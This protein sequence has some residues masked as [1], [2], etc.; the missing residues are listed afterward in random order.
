MARFDAERQALAMMDHPNIARVLDAGATQTGRPYFVMEL[1]RGVR[2]TGFCDEN[3]FDTRQRLELFIQVCQAIQ[4]AHQKGIIH[5]DIKPSNVLVAMVD[6]KALS[7]VIDFGI[8]KAMEEKLTEHTLFTMHG[9]F[10]GTPAYMSPEQAQISGVDVDTRSD[11]YSLGV[12]LYELLTGKTPFDQSELVAAGIDEMRRTLSDRDPHRP[13]TKLDTLPQTELTATAHYRHVEPLKLR[14]DLQGDLDWIVMKALEKDRSRRYQTANGLAVEIQRYLDNEPVTA[15]PPSRIYRFQKLVRRNK[16]T[17]VAVG[18]VIVALTAGFGTSTWLFF[19]E[20]EARQEQFRLR[21][22]ADQARNNEAKLRR[23]AEAQAK[24]TQAAYLISR[25]KLPEANAL[26]G[27]VALPVVHPSL[28]AA[29]V[30]GNLAAWDV[31]R[32]KWRQAADCLLK[33][34]QANQIDKTDMTDAATRDLIKAG[35]VLVLVGDTSGYR[36]FIKTTI[37]HFSGTQNPVAAEQL[38]KLSTILPVDTSV[39][40]SLEPMARV[41]EKSFADAPSQSAPGGLLYAWRALAL[42]RFEYLRGDYTNAIAWAQKSLAYTNNRP[43]CIAMNHAVLAMACH[44]LNQPRLARAELAKVRAMVKTGLPNGFENGLPIS[45]DES[46]FWD[47]W[48]E[49]VILLNEAVAAIEGTPQFPS[50]PTSLP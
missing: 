5:R 48:I 41:A 8:A 46:G 12:L 23:E 21:E 44:K 25:S 16:A 49:S 27:D 10:I 20:R 9:N 36:H 34:V 50:I 38:L 33:M 14:H 2:I 29:G 30:F 4:H 31:T 1:V 37:A 43:T 32:G 28:E 13:S 26:V 39:I 42:A 11:I 19:R 17:F 47:D 15:R 6:G 24:I 22:E 45:S 35:P 7:K 18:A 40:Q 3:H